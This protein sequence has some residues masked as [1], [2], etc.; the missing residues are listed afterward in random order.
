MIAMLLVKAA[1]VVSEDSQP[2]GTMGGV[3]ATPSNRVYTGMAQYQEMVPGTTTTYLGVDFVCM[4]PDTAESN[5]TVQVTTTAG[6]NVGGS[7]TISRAAALALPDIGQGLRRVTG[8]LSSGAALTAATTYRVTF[9]SN[10][11]SEAEGWKIGTA[12]G[13]D[14]VYNAAGVLAPGGGLATF[15]GN[16]R[17]T[18]KGTADNAIDLTVVLIA[19]PVA[20]VVT[21]AIATVTSST[22]PEWCK[23]F[24][25][26]AAYEVPEVTWTASAYTGFRRWE[27]EREEATL[28]GHWVPV[29]VI[30][31]ESQKVYRDYGA[32][33]TVPVRYRVRALLATGAYSDWV[34]TAQ[35]VPMPKGSEVI[36]A[37][38][39]DP[40]LTVAYDREPKVVYQFL[41]PDE[42]VFV[43]MAGVPYQTAFGAPVE[44][45]VRFELDVILN[46]WEEPD[47]DDKGVAAFDALRTL[48][49]SKEIP[50]VIV[51]D[52]EGGRWFAHIQVPEGVSEQPYHVYTTR[53][54]VT[55]LTDTPVVT[56][57][58]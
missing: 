53:V 41:N 44:R 18:Y 38:D 17:A 8:W 34:V 30:T 12:G 26:P 27:I 15:Q 4:V 43:T 1:S 52:H 7:F 54:T 49:T 33:R 35:V 46:V 21:A 9:S 25:H 40:T 20:P 50:Y 24:C 5:L 16:T 10:A 56:T 39:A 29:D 11:A 32:R 6:A 22:P 57:Q 23:I 2:Y 45:G 31:L 51:L 19:Q 58:P 28:L 47:D 42:D 3:G 55:E 48:A 36:F 37:S 13:P 14:S